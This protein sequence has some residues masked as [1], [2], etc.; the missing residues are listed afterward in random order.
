MGHSAMGP[1][2]SKSLRF[3]PKRREFGEKQ[4]LPG[5]WVWGAIGACSALKQEP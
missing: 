5:L 2:Y 1:G 4:G 3:S